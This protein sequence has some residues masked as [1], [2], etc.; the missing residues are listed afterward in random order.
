LSF[1]LFDVLKP[2]PIGWL[3]RSIGGGFGVMVDDVVAAI[4]GVLMVAVGYAI[5]PQLVI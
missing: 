1:R 3:D 5:L 4:M 2:W